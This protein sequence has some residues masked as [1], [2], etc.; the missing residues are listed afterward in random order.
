MPTYLEITNYPTIVVLHI[1]IQILLK[2]AQIV[3][4]HIIIKF[5]LQQL[6]SDTCP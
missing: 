3:E 4:L 6:A 1:E 5:L 2:Y